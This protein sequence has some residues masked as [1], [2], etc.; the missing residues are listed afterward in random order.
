MPKNNPKILVVEDEPD[1]C[2]SLQSYFGRR[3]FLVSTTPSGQEALSIIETSK[4]DIVLLDLKLAEAADINGIE[5][6]KRLREFDKETKVIVI[7]GQFLKEEEIEEILALGVSEYLNKP[8]LLEKLQNMLEVILGRKISS[9]P[10]TQVSK[11]QESKDTSLGS[12]VHELSNLLGV[13]RNK[14]E[15]FTLDIE[16]G[17]SKN[18]SDKELLKTAVEIMNIIIVTVDRAAQAVERI[19]SFGKKK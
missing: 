15:N 13:I 4:P 3:G 10:A 8:I 2:N 1:V 6:L 5:V 19:S 16:D 9:E 12:I 11:P 7:T 17:I 18:K 14:C